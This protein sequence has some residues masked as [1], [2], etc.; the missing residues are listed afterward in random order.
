MGRKAIVI[1]AGIGGIA[2]AI[3]LAHLGFE[4][5]VYERNS[6]P[7]GKIRSSRF[8]GYRFDMGP[9]VFT[10]PRLVDELLLL[11]ASTSHGFSYQK[12][13]I[14]CNYFFED[15]VRI[16]LPSGAKRVSEVLHKEL[17]EDKRQVYK[18]LRKLQNNYESV[19]PV[20]ITASLHKVSHWFNR[21]LFRALIRIPKYGLLTTMNDMNRKQFNNNKTIQIFNRFATYNGSNPYE[22]PGM[23]NII[24][25]LELNIGPYM[26]NGGMVSITKS[27]YEHA[28]SLGVDFL[29]NQAITSINHEAN[30]VTGV[31]I[32][33]RD[34]EAD[35]VV[36][37]MDVHNT[38]NKLLSNLTRPEKILK[39]EKSTSAVVF[40]WGIKKKFSQLDV[41][42][43]FFS[44]NYEK[45]FQTMFLDKS[46]CS[47][48]TVYIHISSKIETSDAPEYGENW[49]V[50]VNA[51]INTGQNWD[52]M[53]AELRKNILSKLN[54]ILD[55]DLEKLIEIEEYMD[56]VKM[57]EMYSGMQGSIYG[58]S[59]NSKMSAFYRHPNFSNQIKGL[60][61]AGVTVHPGGGIPLA[62]NSAKIIEKCVKKDFNLN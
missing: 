15:G 12:L 28:R 43:I 40:Y 20:F 19:Y 34:I 61:F 27:L 45:E 30:R 3:R 13:P 42:N 47:D 26:P 59:S 54:R 56:P 39:Q 62:L 16:A 53:R 24:A 5:T 11:K 8:K 49:F 18:Y 44:E 50:M 58:N 35:L 51:P 21:G 7:G 38:Y 29:F 4:T 17:G 9:S 46:I 60:Y 41:H 2:S 32:D 37:N 36:S 14:S 1:G 33:G 23:L 6:E 10:E 22:A 57:E 48:P 25:H 31:S 55:E 52:Q